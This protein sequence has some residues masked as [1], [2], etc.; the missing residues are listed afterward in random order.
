MMPSPGR[1]SFR[2]DWSLRSRSSHPLDGLD[3]ELLSAST[4]PHSA[5]KAAIDPVRPELQDLGSDLALP[6]SASS[7]LLEDHRQYLLLVHRAVT[8]RQEQEDDRDPIR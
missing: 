5:P 4:V 7:R 6:G 1:R 3:L 2:S 8:A